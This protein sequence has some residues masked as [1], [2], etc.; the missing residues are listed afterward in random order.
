MSQSHNGRVLNIVRGFHLLLFSYSFLV[1]CCSIIWPP[2]PFLRAHTGTWAPRPHTY[3]FPRPVREYIPI[4][5][6]GIL[7]VLWSYH[8]LYK[9]NINAKLILCNRSSDKIKKLVIPFDFA[10]LTALILNTIL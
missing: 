10:R 4:G 9:R 3:A 2:A 5:G 1:I 7:P 6:T 8:T